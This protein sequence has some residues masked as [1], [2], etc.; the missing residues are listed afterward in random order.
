V[1]SDACIRGYMAHGIPPGLTTELLIY[2][3]Q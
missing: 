1:A 3:V 2:T